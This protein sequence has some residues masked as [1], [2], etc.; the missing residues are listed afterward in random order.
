MP[1][2]NLIFQKISVIRIERLV[3]DLCKNKKA[4]T[5]EAALA[6]G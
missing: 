2:I 4:R 3:G 6:R 5:R 1:I